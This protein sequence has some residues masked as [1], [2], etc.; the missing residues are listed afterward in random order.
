MTPANIQEQLERICRSSDFEDSPKVCDV[1]K[2]LVQHSLK[3]DDALKEIQLALML[4]HSN[5]NPASDSGVREIIGRLRKKLSDY[6]AKGGRQD[7]IIFEIPRGQY[8][9]EFHPGRPGN[10][11]VGMIPNEFMDFWT[12]LRETKRVFARNVGII[13]AVLAFLFIV[14]SVR[15]VLVSSPAV[16]SYIR[17]SY[18]AQVVIISLMLVSNRFFLRPISDSRFKIGAPGSERL[19]HWWNIALV[20]LLCLYALRLASLP[21]PPSGPE[22]IHCKVLHLSEHLSNNLSTLAFLMCF[23][24]MEYPDERAKRNSWAWLWWAVLVVITCV[25]TALNLKPVAVA[26][27]VDNIK[28][29][30]DWFEVL[31]SANAGIALAMFCGRLSSP[32]INPPL[33]IVACLYLYALVQITYPFWQNQMVAFPMASVAWLLKCVLFMVI[34]WIVTTRHLILYMESLYTIRTNLLYQWRKEAS[35]GTTAAEDE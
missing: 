23:A 9:V 3:H 24:I 8:K 6:Y 12:W 13:G 26:G 18:V 25:E 21:C 11:P 15:S 30:V 22:S 27:G 33:T 1:L 17:A 29:T 7:E 28:Q 35:Q 5:Y 32:L 20:S 4:G 34:V 10:L 14:I 31:S 19:I 2:F 16:T